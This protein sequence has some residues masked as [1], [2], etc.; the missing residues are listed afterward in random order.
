MAWTHEEQRWVDKI[1]DRAMTIARDGDVDVDRRDLE[2]ALAL[3]H[4]QCPL[5]LQDLS[6]TDDFNLAHDVFGIYRF[7]D[8]DTGA[9]TRGFRPRLLQ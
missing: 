6:E 2:M 7:V 8:R 5:D 9:L 3:C 4:A 1:L